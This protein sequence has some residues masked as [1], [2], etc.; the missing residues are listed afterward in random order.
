MPKRRV[1]VLP[2]Y[3]CHPSPS[4]VRISHFS[5]TITPSF[6]LLL[7]PQFLILNTLIRSWVFSSTITHETGF[8]SKRRNIRRFNDKHVGENNSKP[9]IYIYFNTAYNTAYA[10]AFR[11][12]ERKK[13]RSRGGRGGGKQGAVVEIHR[14]HPSKPAAWR[15]ANI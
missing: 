14:T 12:G 10:N 2:R 3:G 7:P 8:H 5:S 6:L 13:E 11:V 1:R 9:T 4:L 15:L